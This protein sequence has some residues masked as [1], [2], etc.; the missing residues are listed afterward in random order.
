MKVSEILTEGL[1]DKFRSAFGSGQ[2]PS[3]TT[4]PKKTEPVYL[5]DSEIREII[6]DIVHWINTKIDMPEKRKLVAAVA[7]SRV[8]PWEHAIFKDWMQRWATD[9]ELKEKYRKFSKR[10]ILAAYANRIAKTVYDNWW[11]TK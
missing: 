6:S 2:Q 8:K 10:A 11:A 1:L 3:Q 4:E 9:Y 7:N 5:D